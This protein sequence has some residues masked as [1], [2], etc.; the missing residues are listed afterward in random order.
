MT[1]N[2]KRLT[3]TNFLS[4]PLKT[5]F[6]TCSLLL[7]ANSFLIAQDNSPYSRY[8]IG[9]IVP[10]TNVINRGM[11]KISAAYTDFLSI[12]F[13]NP[14]SYT[15]FQS[16]KEARSKKLQSGRVIFDIGINYDSRTL[17][18]PNNP[19]KFRAQNLLFSYL[20]VGVPL[21]SK[22]GFSFGLRP[23]SRIS[24]KIQTREKLAIGDSVYTLYTGDGGSFLPNV[25]LGHRFGKLSIGINAGYLFGKKDYS[26]RR[27]FINDSVEYYNSNHQTKTVFGSMFLQGGLQYTDSL[28][29]S[30]VLTIGATGNLATTLNANQDLIRETFTRDANSGDLRIDSVYEQTGLNGTMKYPSSFTVGFAIEKNKYDYKKASWMMGVDFT[31]TAWSSYR[32]YGIKD[33]TQNTWEIK[34][35]ASLRPIPKKSYFSNVTYRA[36]FNIGPDYINTGKK[37]QQFGASFGL[38]LPVANFSQ[39]ARGQATVINVAFEYG[40]RGNNNNILKENM[41]R[42]SF[43]LSLSDIWFQKR[44]YD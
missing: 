32:Y 18:E 7:A 2:Q 19:A 43:G 35:G 10:S 6:I 14:A 38:G 3:G 21:S 22:T 31:T 26:T 36:G 23:V 16:L 5:I 11:G 15:G 17:Q 1:I 40:K 28:S 29:N 13:S 8:G 30:T 25:G 34:I 42:L 12:N 27:L 9:D 39:L 24:Y 33:F 4:G 41:F 44:K 37:L 20:Q